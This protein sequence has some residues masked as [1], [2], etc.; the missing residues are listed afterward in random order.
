MNQTPPIQLLTIEEL[1]LI[2][3]ISGFFGGFV[4]A[5]FYCFKENCIKKP[6]LVTWEKR[7]YFF[8]GKSIIGIA[9]SVGVVLLGYW[10]GKV[11]TEATALNKL[12]LIS[13]CT[14]GGTISY[15]IL[16]RIGGMLENQLLKKQINELEEKTE[17]ALEKS[18]KAID[19][20]SAI[21]FAQTA[22]SRKTNIDVQL[23]IDQ[24]EA[25]IS[26]FPTERRLN[27]YLGR[28]YRKIG[29][30][31]KGIVV[32]RNFIENLDKETKS[33]HYKIDRADSYY[34][35]A[36]YHSLKAQKEENEGREPNE[37]MRLKNEALECLKNAV[38]NNPSTVESAP[39]DEDFSAIK[40]EPSF[41]QILRLDTVRSPC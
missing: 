27:I 3:I 34:N 21:S 4:S 11:S 39:T 25:I 13:F 9:G 8:T 36:C 24:L 23:S 7:F 17:N 5:I 31:N 15:R 12:Q 38:E 41:S 14:I 40:N 16:P 33:P 18:K 2:V 35:I 28:L 20:S 26:D 29:D 19:Y 32:L 1:L 10:I 37:V 6:F 22:L 30:Y